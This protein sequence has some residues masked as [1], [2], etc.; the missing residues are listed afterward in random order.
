V[1]ANGCGGAA[2]RAFDYDQLSSTFNAACEHADRE[3]AVKERPRANGSTAAAD[4]DLTEMNAGY[5]VVRVGGR[6]RVMSLEESPAVPGCKAPVFSTVPD[7]CAFHLK[8]KKKIGSGNR[9]HVVGIGKWWIGHAD[10][11]QYDAV[12]YA[13]GGTAATNYNLWTGFSCEP[14]PGNCDRYLAHLRENVCGED[15]HLCEYLLNW[16]AYAVQYPGKPGEV[17]V[18]LRGKEGVGK[19]ETAKQFGRIFGAHFRHVVHAKHLTGHFNAHLQQCSVLFADEAFFAGDRSH[20][21]T[22]KALITEETLMIEPKGLD[23]FP[24]RNCIHLIMSSNSD[25]VVPAGAEARR[26]F[27]L[28]VADTHMQDGD[29]FGAIARE[30]G[31]GGREALLDLLLN[32]D[33]SEFDVRKVPHTAALAEQKAHS[34]RGIDRLIE[35]VAHCGLLP[36]AHMVHRNVA[37]TSGEEEGAGFYHQARGLAPELKFDSQIVIHNA[38]KKNWGCESW[39]SGNQR[40][41]KFP[42]LV[43]LRARFDQKHGQQ[44]W[45]DIA[46]WEGR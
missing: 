19:G 44:E 24:V 18:V 40:G 22:L 30:M 21:S 15:D 8:R 43:E 4:A 45:P 35:C 17:A 26:Y 37:I 7:F 14:I 2:F 13:P 23:P 5:A 6:T 3:R 38:L 16:M 33:L 27:V 11:R 29:Y 12:V 20:E 28:N 10:R 39:K 25:W 34:R 1:S 9:T 31:N 42:P 46:E 41:I 36:A 32:R